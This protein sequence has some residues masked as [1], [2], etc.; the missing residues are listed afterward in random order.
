MKK[1]YSNPCI[2]CGTERIILKTWKEKIYDSTVINTET[3]CPNRE[4]QKKVNSD[5]KKQQ[6]KYIALKLRSEQRAIDRRITKDAEK[7][8]KKG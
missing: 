6:D 7:A 3:V 5:N 4:C 8:L 1:A 2:R